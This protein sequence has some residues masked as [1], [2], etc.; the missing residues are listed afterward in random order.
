MNGDVPN[1]T[2][3]EHCKDCCCARSW[4]ALG[5]TEYTGHS[6]PEHIRMLREEVERLRES[7][8]PD[9]VNALRAAV[10]VIGTWHNMEGPGAVEV[11]PIYLRSS[12]E[13]KPIRDALSKAGAPIR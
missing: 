12:P 6:I 10:E 5:I 4:A 9:L 7:A 3:D 2:P 11:W 1:R 13:M 8:V